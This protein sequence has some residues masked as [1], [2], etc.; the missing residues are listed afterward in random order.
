MA[1]VANSPQKKPTEVRAAQATKG[2]EIN[3]KSPLAW[4]AHPMTYNPIFGL[5]GNRELLQKY[6]IVSYGIKASESK[7]D[8]DDNLNLFADIKFTNGLLD[9]ESDYYNYWN[10]DVLMNG[11]LTGLARFVIN[12]LEKKPYTF[13]VKTN[14]P[15][16]K[17]EFLKDLYKLKAGVGKT[18]S[19]DSMIKSLWGACIE[20]NEPDDALSPPVAAKK[21]AAA[22]PAAKAT[23]NPP[24]AI[25]NGQYITSMGDKDK[26]Q[27]N[28]LRKRAAAASG[29]EREALMKELEKRY[30][31]TSRE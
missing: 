28:A 26:I 13:V 31:D 21:P 14:K 24:F 11:T 30:G 10:N 20:I 18:Q 1:A 5:F 2:I 17:G 27:A 7:Q 25:V 29:A 4:L 15:I 8:Q 22:P 19:K 9:T 6:N 16:V 12:N 3:V 23:A